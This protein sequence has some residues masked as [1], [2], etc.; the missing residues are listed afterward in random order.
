M[1][2]TSKR[3]GFCGAAVVDMLRE[4]PSRGT[5]KRDRLPT[6]SRSFQRKCSGGFRLGQEV[7]HDDSIIVPGERTFTFCSRSLTSPLTHPVT[8]PLRAGQHSGQSSPCSAFLIAFLDL[9]S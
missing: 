4:G 2:S 7:I 8:L 9:S 6:W 3:S 5:I 1:L